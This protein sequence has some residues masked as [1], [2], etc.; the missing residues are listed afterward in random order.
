ME[1]KSTK[2][3]NIYTGLFFKNGNQYLRH[4]LLGS[5]CVKSLQYKCKVHIINI[6]CNFGILLMWVSVQISLTAQVA[7]E[8]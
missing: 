8:D 4:E 5:V 3:E 7:E 6:Q 2:S 1:N